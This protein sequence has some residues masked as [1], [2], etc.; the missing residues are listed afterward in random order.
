[1]ENSE[2]RADFLKDLPPVEFC[3]AYGSALLGNHD[4]NTMVDYILGVSDPIKWHSENL[5]L[6]RDHYASWMVHLG[7]AKMI[8]LVADKVGVGVHFNPFVNWN[9]RMIKYGVVRS[10]NLVQDLLHWKHFYLSGR[11]QKPVNIHVDTLD[12]ANLNLVNLKAA[13]S[14]A[15]LLLP[16]EFSEEQLY[17]KI[18]GLSYMGDVRMLFAED[19]NKVNK[20]VRGQFHLF[21][22][23]YRP[24]LEEYAA[25]DL[26]RFPFTGG[27]LGNIIQNYEL[28]ATQ[29][30][31]SSLPS[32]FKSC[33]GI[34]ENSKSSQSGQLRHEVTIGSREEAANCMKKVLRRKVMVSSTRQA[35]SGLLATGGVHAAWYLS[36]KMSKWWKS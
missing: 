22:T 17:A 25:K 34:R 27:H 35:I 29:T 24:L 20:I 13:T 4:K 6:N 21:H 14:A 5:E 33:M 1:M 12:I 8:T 30:L 11:L 7:G 2:V 36:N 23:M 3:C 19:K 31:V 28:R 18:C 9:N 16:P 15:L 10:H 32:T 26:L